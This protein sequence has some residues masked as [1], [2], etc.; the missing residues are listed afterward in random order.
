MKKLIFLA[1]VVFTGTVFSQTYTIAN[2]P[3]NLIEDAN[4]VMINQQVT[5]HVNDVNE[6]EYSY[7]SVLMVLNKNG[8][9]DLLPM[10]YYNSETKVKN[11]EA[12]VYD[13]KGEEIEKFKKRDF[14]DISAVDG[15]SLYTDDR[16]L[17]INYTATSY[18]YTLEF[19]VT[20]L[21]EDTAFLPP[22]DPIPNY[23]SSVLSSSYSIDVVPELNLKYK[24]FDE[25]GRINSTQNGT[26]SIF[27][28]SNL[29]SILDE[30]HGPTLSATVPKVLFSLDRFNLKGIQGSTA[31]WQEFGIWMNNRLLNGVSEIPEATKV[32]IRNL[33]SGE[34]SPMERAKKVYQ[35][36]Q[37]N[38]RYISVQVGI[39]GW[40]PMPAKEVDRL[41]YG[42][43][44]ALT[45]YTKAL[46]SVAE[47]PSYYTLV[48]HNS[49][50]VNILSDFT[51]MQ[52]NHVILAIPDGEDYVWLECTSQKKPFGFLGSNTD[53]RDVLLITPEG[54][55]I[56]HTH[57]YTY[58]ENT[59]KTQGKVIL[60]VEGDISVNVKIES[61]G[62][63]YNDRYDVEF[64]KI[65]DQEAFYKYYWDYLDNITITSM[66]FQNDKEQVKFM[67]DVAFEAR[68]FASFAGDKMIFNLNVLNRSTF[69]PRRYANRNFPLQLSRGYLDED[70]VKLLLPEGYEIS[71]IPEPVAINSPF[72]EYTASTEIL[73]DG[74]LMYRRKV[75]R[76]EGAFP[77]ERYSEFR[78]Y[79]KQ[80][81]K[82]DDQKIILLKK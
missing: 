24:I 46:L 13:E 47:V 33:V 53:D 1:F 56:A 49:S 57:K 6:M 32:K 26:K 17:L 70:E 65:E 60:N 34:N 23:N 55:K 20:V 71:Y 2:V 66:K 67:E 38:T 14:L 3:Q 48:N 37:D 52:G 29:K 30:N 41:G 78:S 5:V 82:S 42:D 25:E 39:G 50:K 11:L 76:Y 73:P 4:S 54:G 64:Q 51:S 9:N 12:I 15:E 61:G 16:L 8:K 75:I 68:S 72:G 27:T 43:C 69:I 44:K 59:L 10:V 45:N 35:Y 19:N 21:T 40:K 79:L 74:N 31:N 36:M 58:D 77:K 62:I 28:I 22:F 81:A 80:I 63:Q 18:P 7:H